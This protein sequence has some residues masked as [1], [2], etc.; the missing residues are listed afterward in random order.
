METTCTTDKALVTYR[1]P[2][3]YFRH[4]SS[5]SNALTAPLTFYYLSHVSIC[6]WLQ[7]FLPGHSN[8]QRR[9]IG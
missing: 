6:G 5:E 4:S 7:V 2:E 8:A 1:K 3:H 9:R